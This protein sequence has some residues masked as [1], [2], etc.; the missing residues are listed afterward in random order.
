MGMKTGYHSEAGYTYASVASDGKR[1]LIAVL[2]G[3]DNPYK[4]FRDAIRLF[5]AAFEEEEEERLLFNK[6][7]NTFS[8]K[9]SQG[10]ENLK[11]IL[12]EDV[13]ISYYPSEE[14]E[15]TIELNWEYLPPPIKRG[16]YVGAIK[17]FDQRGNALESSPLIA[18][19][20][21]DRAFSV[22]IGDAIRGDW[23]CPKALQ[24]VLIL[25]LSF[26]VLLTLFGLCRV[27]GKEKS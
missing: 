23:D 27:Q 20:N 19:V 1:T 10:K 14:P 2:L 12:R 25:L 17:I 18:K 7:E 21:V 4:R 13:T 6:D 9:L 26:G 22:L 11:A 16:D 3:C 24:R 5:E 15:I 8:R